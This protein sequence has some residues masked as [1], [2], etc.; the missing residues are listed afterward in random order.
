MSILGIQ[1][2]E[3]K[4]ETWDSNPICKAGLGKELIAHYIPILAFTIT[5]FVQIK[6]VQFANVYTLSV[7]FSSGV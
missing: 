7:I 2:C 4:F 6:Y 3:I 5:E 1:V